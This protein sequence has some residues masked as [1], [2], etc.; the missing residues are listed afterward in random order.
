MKLRLLISVL[1]AILIVVLMVY[2]GWRHEA[3]AIS[4]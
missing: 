1:A 2:F 3:V 4:R